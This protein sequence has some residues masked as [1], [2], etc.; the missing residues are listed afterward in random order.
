MQTFL[1]YPNF[2]RCAA[3]LD[4]KRLKKQIIEAYQIINGQGWTNHPCI[5][6]WNGNRYHLVQYAIAM[7][8][9]YE[10]RDYRPMLRQEIMYWSRIFKPCPEPWWLG[11]ERLHLSHRSMLVQKLPEH[12]GI[13]WPDVPR[14]LRY[15]WPGRQRCQSNDASAQSV[16]RT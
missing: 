11:D 8:D 6:M 2:K 15:W 14:D 9:E 13:F 1:P 10:D 5:E 7:C 12:Y 3:V 4:I 16:T